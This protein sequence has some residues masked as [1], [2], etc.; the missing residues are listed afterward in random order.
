[1][2]VTPTFQAFVL[3]QLGRITPAPRAKPM[4]GGVGIYAGERFF[5]LIADD[6]LYLK[7]DDVTRA[8]FVAAGMPPFRPFGPDAQ[9]MQYYAV[10]AD[11][12]EDAEALE[13][14]VTRA[15]AAADRKRR[16]KPRRP[17]D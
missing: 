14:W 10:S 16:P 7:A 17:P 4:F 12:L 3:E 8:E 13:P 11:V 9:I 2:A 6:V 1:V 5:A 15:L